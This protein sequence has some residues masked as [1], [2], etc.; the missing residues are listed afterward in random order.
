MKVF[1]IQ[2]PWKVKDVEL[3][4]AEGEVKVLVEIDV[5]TGTSM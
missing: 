4:L 1:G 3:S 2:T 5:K